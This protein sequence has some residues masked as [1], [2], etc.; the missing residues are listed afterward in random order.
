MVL[1]LV[2]AAGGEWKNADFNRSRGAALYLNCSRR[3]NVR[4]RMDILVVVVGAF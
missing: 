4:S 1:L 2:A 3:D